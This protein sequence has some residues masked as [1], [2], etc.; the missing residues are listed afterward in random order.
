MNDLEDIYRRLAAEGTEQ[1]LAA[2]YRSAR[3]DGSQSAEDAGCRLT[4]PIPALATAIPPSATASTAIHMLHSLPHDIQAALPDQLLELAQRSAAAALRR[5][6]LALELDGA[7]H[8]YSAEEWLP[9]VY[10]IAGPGLR[11]ARLADEPPT[12]VRTAQDAIS[13]LSRTIGEFDE[14]PE[15]APGSLAETL[16]RLLAVWAFTDAALQHRRAS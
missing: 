1:Q 11:S 7:D 15:E 2:R 6:H 12:L 9:A 13:W 3:R 5:C 4:R 10:D 16:G 8:G 14:R